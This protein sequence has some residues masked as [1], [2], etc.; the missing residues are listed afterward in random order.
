MFHGANAEV[1]RPLLVA[2]SIALVLSA[3]ARHWYPKRNQE[4][5]RRC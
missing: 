5:G 3:I 2:V 4:E 1:E